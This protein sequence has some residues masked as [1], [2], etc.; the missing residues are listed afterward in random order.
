[1][2]S[3]AVLVLGGARSGK[4]RRALAIADTAPRRVLIAT[5]EAFDAE[6][7]QRIAAHRAEREGSGWL[8]IEAPVEIARA[9][10]DADGGAD[11]VI[12]VDCLT[13]WLTNL[14]LADHDLTAATDDLIAT[15]QRARSRV[16]LVSNEVGHGIVPETRLGRDFRDAQGRLN[17]DMAAVSC[18]VEFMIA[19]LPLVLK[20]A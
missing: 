9:V 7:A 2:T 20:G 6:M 1:M 12:V 11:D 4:S 13:L 3:R 14:M 8:T 19:G 18:R 16:V 17:Q 15:L 10:R 5:A